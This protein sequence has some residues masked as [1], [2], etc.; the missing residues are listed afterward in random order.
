MI[1]VYER[2][3]LR[4]SS[5]HRDSKSVRDGP[6]DRGVDVTAN[7]ANGIQPQVSGPGWAAHDKT[8]LLPAFVTSSKIGID[9]QLAKPAI[10]AQPAPAKPAAPDHTDRLPSSERGMLVFVSAILGVGTLAIVAM[11]IFGR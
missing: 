4:I 10:P 6:M 3:T 7:S 2:V 9:D 11:A 8:L 1:K 5:A